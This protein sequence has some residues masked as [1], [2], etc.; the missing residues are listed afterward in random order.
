MGFNSGGQNSFIA[1]INVT[2]F[3][4]VMLVLLIIFMVTAPMM[5]QGLEV[6]LPQ[7][8]TVQTLPQGKDHMVLTISKDGELYLDEYKVPR[9]QLAGHLERLVKKPNKFLYLRADRAVPYGVVVEVM[10]QVKSV[11][12]DRLGVVAEPDTDPSRKKS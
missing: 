6:D 10:G 7:T 12:I 8:Q 4:D 5:T 9:E 1:E 11:G 2:P 3:V